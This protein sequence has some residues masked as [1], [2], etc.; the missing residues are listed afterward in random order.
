MFPYDLSTLNSSFHP[1]MSPVPREAPAAGAEAW[2]ASPGPPPIPHPHPIHS[3]PALSTFRSLCPSF[4]HE[5]SP[6]AD[7]SPT[8]PA[9]AGMLL[10]SPGGTDTTG[11]SGW[12]ILSRDFRGIFFKFSFCIYLKKRGERAQRPSGGCP[13]LSP[14]ITVI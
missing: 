4:R 12:R 1:W 5:L 6:W 11:L 8:P 3:E 2:E 9:P 10:F 14:I 13:S 7:I